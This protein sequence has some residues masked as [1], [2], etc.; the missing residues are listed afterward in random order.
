MLAF[1]G[2]ILR[3]LEPQKVA[4]KA[5]RDQDQNQAPRGV[6]AIVTGYIVR[7]LGTTKNS[8]MALSYG[9]LQFC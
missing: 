4:P 1:K 5:K 8:K 6:R 3:V 2:E 9:F 7:E